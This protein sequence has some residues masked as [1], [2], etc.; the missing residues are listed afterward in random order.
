MPLIYN[1]LIT[2]T[3]ASTDETDEREADYRERNEFYVFAQS[4]V[5][6]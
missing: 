2:N 1:T 3:F 4:S 6:A 5:F